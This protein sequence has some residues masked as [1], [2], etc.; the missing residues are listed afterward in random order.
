MIGADAKNRHL[1]G[2]TLNDPSPR[3]IGGTDVKESSRY[4]YFTTVAGYGSFCGG[5][6]VAP[7]IVLSAAHVRK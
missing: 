2:N 7:D 6:L 4:P 5:A 1:R 3:I